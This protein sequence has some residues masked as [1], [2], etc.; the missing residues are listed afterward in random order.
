MDSRDKTPTTS[1][2]VSNTATWTSD[3]ASTTKE[4]ANNNAETSTTIEVTISDKASKSDR[5][6]TTTEGNINSAELINVS[7]GVIS[8]GNTHLIIATTINSQSRY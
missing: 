4:G 1:K 8:Q 6:P 2:G 3:T 7:P 5:A